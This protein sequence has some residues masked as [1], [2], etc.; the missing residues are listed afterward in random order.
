MNGITVQTW[1]ADRQRKY[2]D[3]LVLFK[4][5]ASEEMKRK[6]LAYFSEVSNVPQ[7]DS[8]MTVLIN[9][10]TTIMR[11]GTCITQQTP[12]ESFAG[13]VKTAVCA[14][15]A[16]DKAADELKAVSVISEIQAKEVELL[17]LQDRITELEDDND[18]K[19]DEIEE[20][21]Y[22]LEAK[23]EE[24]EE[25]HN[26]LLR[27]RPGVKIVTYSNLPDG[28]RQMYDRIRD[29]TPLYAS[30]FTEMQAESLTAE[31]REPIARQVNEL[32]MKRDELWKNIDDWAEGK[33]IELHIEQ[34]KL[35]ELPDNTMLK[36]MQAANRIERLKE[37]IRR[38][39][40]SILNHEA[41]GKLNLKQNAQDKL[42]TYKQELA[43]LEKIG[44]E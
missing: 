33:K 12:V 27:L 17:A 2:A 39:E 31:E 22:D 36:G 28:I 9:K 15:V 18:D 13:I 23:E 21:Q 24:I 35:E 34:T 30:L 41:K 19:T 20:L 10:L 11:T 44:K 43:E 1:L 4:E 29:I 25:L 32:Y 16:I 14:T 8:H 42:N 40:K 37:N 38:T 3:G 7:F 5:H 6:F 26:N